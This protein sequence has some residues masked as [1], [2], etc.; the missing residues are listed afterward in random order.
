LG[1]GVGVGVMGLFGLM[2]LMIAW[3]KLRL[4]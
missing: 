1:V 2:I 4:R 3:G